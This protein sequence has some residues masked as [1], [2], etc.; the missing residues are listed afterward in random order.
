MVTGCII[1]TTYDFMALG[2]RTCVNL[3]IILRSTDI[4]ISDYRQTCHVHA[5]TTANTR[6][7]TVANCK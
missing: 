2:H 3:K 6:D 4:L 5:T 1:L 7:V